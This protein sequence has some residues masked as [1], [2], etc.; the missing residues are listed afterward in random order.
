MVGDPDQL[1]AFEHSLRSHGVVIDSR[2]PI[3]EDEDRPGI[4]YRVHFRGQ[5]SYFE[6]LD[7]WLEDTP[8]DELAIAFLQKAGM[9]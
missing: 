9:L 3:I 1:V 8:G 5:A 4:T 6:V 7:R 2:E